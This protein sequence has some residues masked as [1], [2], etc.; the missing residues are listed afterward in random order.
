[1][2]RKTLAGIYLEPDKRKLLYALSMNTQNA[3]WGRRADVQK[4]PT[5]SQAAPPGA[6]SEACH[7]QGWG[8]GGEGA[9]YRENHLASEAGLA[10]ALHGRA[11]LSIPPP[12]VSRSDPHISG[13]QLPRYIPMQLSPVFSKVAI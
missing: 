8:E 6:A 7:C 4:L 1:M 11:R 5:A 12:P 13:H 3:V 9:S 10:F 2:L